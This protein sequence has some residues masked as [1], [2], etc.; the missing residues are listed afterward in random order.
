MNQFNVRQ[1]TPSGSSTPVRPGTTTAASRLVRRPS[2]AADGPVAPATP[3][4]RRTTPAARTDK[5][6]PF[7]L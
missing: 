2:D 5:R 6:E 4:S 3:L 1:R 7:R